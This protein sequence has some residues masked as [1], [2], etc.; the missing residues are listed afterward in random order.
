V[1]DDLLDLALGLHVLENLASYRAVDLHAVD[2]CGNGDE[3]VCVDFLVETVGLLLVKSDGVLGLVLDCTG[4]V[5]VLILLGLSC[6]LFSMGGMSLR[7]C[8]VEHCR[9]LRLRI[10]WLGRQSGPLIFLPHHNPQ[11]ISPSLSSCM[12]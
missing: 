9:K 11:L 3:T 6:S 2:K 10:L 12:R 5:L 1:A 7:W 8:C 4:I